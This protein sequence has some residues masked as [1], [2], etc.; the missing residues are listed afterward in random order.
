VN[1]DLKDAR[2]LIVDDQTAN[3][4]LLEEYLLFTGYTQVKSTTD[5]REVIE[6]VESFRPHLLL[7]DLIMPY[8]NGY[9]IME[10]IKS[11]MPNGNLMPI[12]VLTSDTSEEAKRKSLSE[13]ASDFLIKP[14]DAIEVGLRIKNLLF[15]AYLFSEL[16]KSNTVLEEKVL[17]RTR[18]LQIANNRLTVAKN[19]AEDSEER[20]RMLFNSNLDSITVFYFDAEGNTS[21]FIEANKAA[22]ELLEYSAEEFKKIS[23]DDIEDN[24]SDAE[25]VNRFKILNEKGRLRFETVFKQRHGSSCHV[26]VEAVKIEFKGKTAAMYI[27][28][29]ITEKREY[30]EAIKSQNKVLKEIAW[31]QSHLVRAPL[32]RML[33]VIALLED[34][35]CDDFTKSGMIKI[36]TDSAAELDQI[37]REISQ[38]TYASKIFD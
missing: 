25:I 10:Q 20:Y 15:S 32:A 21:T 1:S 35:G 2:I 5:P 7:L 14:F 4:K 36:V 19:L 28:R 34:D 29:D 26:E 6:L 37:I 8:L 3:V 23:I 16:R 13:G 27:A 11:Q 17:E 38:K 30:M 9:Q 24:V 33:G 18:E 22:S 12:L 31:T